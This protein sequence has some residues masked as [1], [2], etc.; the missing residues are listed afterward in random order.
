ML[1]H[2]P[3]KL[4]RQAPDDVTDMVVP[5]RVNPV[6]DVLYVTLEGM[7][8]KATLDTWT[9]GKFVSPAPLPMKA[10]ALTVCVK[11]EGPVT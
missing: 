1:V 7:V 2:V 10:A 4:A 6:K 8:V 9:P 11:V 3:E 5:A